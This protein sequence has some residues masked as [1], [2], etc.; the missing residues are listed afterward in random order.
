M[1]GWMPDFPPRS[2]GI[3]DTRWTQIH[4]VQNG[5]TQQRQGAL[6]GIA[7]QYWAP[8]YGHIFRKVG[9]GDRARDLTQGF[10]ADVIMGRGLV[11]QARK[12]KGR[13]RSLLLSAANNYLR[14]Q[15]RRRSSTLRAP[16]GQL[17]SLEGAELTPAI[18]A[19]ADEDPEQQFC[20][21]W[22]VGLLNEVLAT[23]EANCRAAGQSL[24]WQVFCRRVLDPVT[25]GRPAASYADICAELGIANQTRAN[26][27]N[28]TVRR[29][30]EA[31]L[32]R[33]VRRDVDCD[34]EV[35]QEI[36][37]LIAILSGR[38]TRNRRRLRR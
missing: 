20:R 13:F 3:Q 14:D 32:R 16:K 22:A 29:K 33:R 34:A 36:R 8:V 9:D 5:D 4:L 12:K 11:Q 24:H 6:A 38:E 23:V 7:E 19:S 2:A 17:V 27:M 15:H 18:S 37:E 35:D 31:A 28:V 26:T 10:F 25:E 30:F 21:L 1:S